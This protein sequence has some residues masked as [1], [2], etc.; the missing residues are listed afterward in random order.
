MNSMAINIVKPNKLKNIHL[1]E[2][3]CMKTVISGLVIVGVELL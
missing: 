1:N 3:F 2:V